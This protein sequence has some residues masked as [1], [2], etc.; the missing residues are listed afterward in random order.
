MHV[1]LQ[2]GSGSCDYPAHMADPHLGLK[3]GYQKREIPLAIVTVNLQSRRQR[4][5]KQCLTKMQILGTVILSV[6][7]LPLFK[8]LEDQDI[9]GNFVVGRSVVCAFTVL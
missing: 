5:P 1:I 2:T 4:V 8:C 6:F 3:R 7:D 9:P